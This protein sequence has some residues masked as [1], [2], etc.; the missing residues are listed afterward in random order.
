MEAWLKREA[1]S[2]GLAPETTVTVL[3]GTPPKHP[4]PSSPPSVIRAGF[5]GSTDRL[6]RAAG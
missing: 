2:G 3:E 5:P 1:D 4:I 6:R